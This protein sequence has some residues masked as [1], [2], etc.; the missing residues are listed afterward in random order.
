M[1]ARR[2]NLPSRCLIPDSCW[3]Q[4]LSARADGTVT[5]SVLAGG[6]T[7]SVTITVTG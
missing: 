5:I 2:R 1:R 7:D 3:S 4:R 6:V